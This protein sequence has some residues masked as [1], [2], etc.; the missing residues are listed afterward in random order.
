MNVRVGLKCT[1]PC[2]A[3]TVKSGNLPSD[4]EKIMKIHIVIV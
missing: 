4:M 1:T 3:K 2:A